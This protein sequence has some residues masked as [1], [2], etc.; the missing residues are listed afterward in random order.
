MHSYFYDNQT[1]RYIQQFIRLFSGF[2]VEMGKKDNGETV[3]QT[4]PVRYGDIS[5]MAAHI[6]KE[7]SENFQSSVPFISCYI[8]D[9]RISPERRANHNYT[10]TVQLSEKAIGQPIHTEEG[11]IDTSP[12]KY[13]DGEI[14]NTYS[15]TRYMAVPYDLTFSVDIWTSSTEQKLQLLEQILVLYNPSINIHT[16]SNLVDW[17]TLSYVELTGTTWS[18][19]SIPQGIDDQLDIATL[20]FNVPI[21]ISP[22]AKVQRQSLIHTI[23]NRIHDVDTNAIE[24]GWDMDDNF[25][26]RLTSY[27]IVTLEQY[28]LNYRDQQAELLLEK[29]IHHAEPEKAL[30]SSTEWEPV[31]EQYGPLRPGISQ[32][33]LRR[34]EYVEDTSEDII[35]YLYWHSEDPKKIVVDIDEDTLP[36]NDH[37]IS[38]I[39]D[40]QRAYPGDGTLPLP[41][42][43]HKY[44]VLDEMPTGELWNYSTAQPYDIVEW[45]GSDWV[46]AF[47]ASANTRRVYIENLMDGNQY[48]WTGEFW[49]NSSEGVYRPG[50]WRLYL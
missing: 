36:K 43:G 35:G 12:H 8:T 19:R 18:S 31:I 10:N 1:R 2:S 46:V 6:L 50:F 27:S 33:R 15:V 37:V 22:P 32:I 9:M 21:F 4:V 23:I 17:T 5:R 34:A 45:N 44:L 30:V 16:N 29:E 26:S 38:A 20:T 47:N 14:G 28:P 40:P 25:S 3:Y 41:V 48:E 11:G 13:V 42:A 39:V 7:N 49:Q 24:D